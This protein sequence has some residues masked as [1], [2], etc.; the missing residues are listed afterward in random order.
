MNWESSSFTHTVSAFIPCSAIRGTRV[1]L[2]SSS[3][4]PI[5][6]LLMVYVRR[7]AIV[8]VLGLLS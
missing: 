1:F 4:E 2:K 5:C 6:P 7:C 3:H 8:I